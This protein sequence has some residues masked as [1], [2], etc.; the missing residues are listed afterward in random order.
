MGLALPA[1]SRLTLTI[2]GKDFERPGATGP[3]RGVA[4]FTHDYP[5][6]RAPKLCAGTN[7]LNTAGQHQSYLL[8]PVLPM[9]YTLAPSSARPAPIDPPSF[10]S[11][12]PR[13]LP[14]PDP[15]C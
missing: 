15:F 1:G 10:R 6:D 11:R 4:W 13:L 12:P 3:F 8:L 5:T 9:R 2:Q 7:P 14:P